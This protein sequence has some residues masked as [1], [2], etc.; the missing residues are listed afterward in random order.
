MLVRDADSTVEVFMLRR[1]SQ[2]AFA[3]STMVFP[4]GGVDDRDG[5]EG[6]PWAG[7]SPVQWGA[8]LG[9]SAAEAQMFVA[10]AIREVFEE[11]GVLLAGPSAGGPLARRRGR[12]LAR[13]A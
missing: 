11:C 4:G 6:L 7:P 12:P 10:A 9:C 2:M 8:R 3:P 1:V 5:D 13:R